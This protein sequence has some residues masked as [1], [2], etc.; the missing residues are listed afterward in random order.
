MRR[1]AIT[2]RTVLRG[3]GIALALPWLEAMAPLGALAREEPSSS[4]PLR[5]AFL[6]VPN[7]VDGTNWTPQ[8]EGAE[9][10]LSPILAPLEPHRGEILVLSGLAHDKARANGD[11]PGDHARSAAAFLTG[12]QPRKTAGADIR[13]GVSV[14]QVAA[15]H[16]GNET[17]VPS[18]EL[19]CE[20]AR[21]SGSC[22]SGYS[23]A[24]SSS[25]A[26]ST[27][28]TPLGKETSPR[29]AFERLFRFEGEGSAEARARRRLE[30]R[31]V[32]DYV[33]EEARRLRARLGG[34]DQLKLDEYLA[35]VRQLERRI[36][37]A[38]RT[39]ERGERPPETPADLREHVR[40][41]LDVSVLAFRS[42]LTRI[43][44]FMLANEGSNRSYPFLGVKGGHHQLSHHGGDEQKIRQ[45]RA[46]NRFHVSQLSYLL[47]ELRQATEGEETLLDRSM[48]VYGSGIREGNRH[49]HHDLP[50]VLAGRGGGSLSPGRHVRYP[51]DTPACNL[52]LSLLDAVGVTLPRFGDSTGRLPHLAG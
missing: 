12:C 43:L 19:G 3:A 39:A 37:R 36:E 28:H 23:C 32:L 10:A 15:Q 7:G 18:L 44:T 9:F 41:L 45:I 2:R 14:D 24:Y 31:S 42:D 25:I 20:P 5:L 40:L 4:P 49:D 38:E 26:W 29:Q 50:I 35:A 30:R 52:F 21:Q 34:T 11:G 22:D 1:R 8:G 46:I 33:S 17:S 51:K 13:A 16:R 27:P 48:I 6:Y 47:H